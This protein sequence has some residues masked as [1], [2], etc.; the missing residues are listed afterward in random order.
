[1]TL[2]DAATLLERLQRELR[3]VI[4]GQ[5]AVVSEILIASS[6]AATACFAAC[7]GWPR[8]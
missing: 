3:K 7:R 8:R 4:V 2:A 1:M 5:D 6:P